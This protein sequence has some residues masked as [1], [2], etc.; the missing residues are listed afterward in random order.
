MRIQLDWLSFTLPIVND[1]SSEASLQMSI[2]NALRGGLGD[3]IADY[4]AVLQWKK[5]EHGRA[6]YSDQWSALNHGLRILYSDKRDDILIEISGAGC[7]DLRATG[8]E[9]RL[10]ER[11]QTRLSR[12]DIA[13]D[14]ECDTKPSAFVAARTGR[15]AS[16]IS[17]IQSV[18]GETVYVGSR[19]SETYVRVYRYAEPHPRHKLLRIEHVFRRKYARTIAS[20]ILVQ[21]IEQ[22]VGAIGKRAGWAHPNWRLSGDDSDTFKFPRPEREAGG[23]VFWL[24]KSAAPAFQRLVREGVIE[25]PQAFIERYFLIDES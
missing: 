4:M 7:D 20:E 15:K 18:T 22:V 24:I 21:G 12:L 11:V 25:D 10:L 19:S 9:N 2:D 6:P 23:T 16:S 8:L 3:E 14:I 13:C 5:D 17:D 1:A